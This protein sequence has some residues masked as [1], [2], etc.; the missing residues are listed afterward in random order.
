MKIYLLKGSTGR[1]DSHRWWIVDVFATE[2]GA[3]CRQAECEAHVKS[4]LR[5]AAAEG[6]PSSFDAAMRANEILYNAPP[7]C[8]PK[9]EIDRDIFYSVVGPLELKP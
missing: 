4:V 2:S 3:L 1:Y 5:Q 6:G 8:D 9:M 7:A